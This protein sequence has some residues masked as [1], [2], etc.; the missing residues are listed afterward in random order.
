MKKISL[1]LLCSV[2]IL[3]SFSPAFAFFGG[4][5]KE[6]N[7]ANVCKA[8]SF[9]EITGNCKEGDI[10]LFT[11]KTWGNEQFPIA[12]SGIVCNIN[13]QVIMNNSGVVCVY[14]EKR[15]NKF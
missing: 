14:T 5:G 12:V 7:Q 2:L 1:S 15:I 10:L 11:P 13:H 3:S 8:E 6:V 9:E 4:N